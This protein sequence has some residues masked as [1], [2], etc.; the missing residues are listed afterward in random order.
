[1]PEGGWL[2]LLALGSNRRHHRHG[3][4]AGVL[5]AAMIALAD[6]MTVIAVSPTIS[7]APLG[8]SHRRYANGAALVR[9]SDLPP[10]LLDRV[11]AIERKFGRRPG[12]R[13]WGTRVLDL[14]IVLWEGGAWH[15]PWLTIP[16]RALALRDFVLRPASAL[17][18][19]W[20]D[21]RTGLTLRQLRARLT[22]AG[23]LPKRMPPPRAPCSI[24]SGA[25]VRALSSV[26]RATD[27]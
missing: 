19:D 26:G 11:K 2:Y 9:S 4:P 25:C 13:R 23:T 27:F 15:S 3:L 5:V 8:P 1:M 22:R 16:H 14:D 20:R 24:K 18:A 17:A 21:P 6:T 10:A 12:G 7:S